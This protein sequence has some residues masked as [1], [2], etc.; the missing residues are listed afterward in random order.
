MKKR[1]I[2]LPDYDSKADILY[3]DYKEFM[4]LMSNNPDEVTNEEFCRA[5]ML[6]IF[7]NIHTKVASKLTAFQVDTLI[8]KLG[9]AIQSESKHQPIIEYNK[10]KYGFIHFAEI[11]YGEL[12]DLEACLRANDKIA[13]TS[14][15]YRPIV[16]KIKKTYDKNGEEVL[17]YNIEPYET[18]DFELFKNI[19]LDIIDGYEKLFTKSFSDLR[20]HIQS[21]TA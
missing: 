19:S 9:F 11:E 3:R 20:N 1:E 2:N 8:K 5:A 18:M 14:I 16:G 21:F 10:V 12:V 17:L 13:L 4:D 6:K 7:Y 15:L